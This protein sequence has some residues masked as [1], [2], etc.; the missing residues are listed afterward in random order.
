MTTPDNEIYLQSI[1]ALSSLAQRLADDNASLRDQLSVKAPSAE[2]NIDAF[3]DTPVKGEHNQYVLA[4][5][6]TGQVD[7]LR[8]A[9]H[10]YAPESAGVYSVWELVEVAADRLIELNRKAGTRA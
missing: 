2:V 5:V 10:D 9:L 4:K 1:K 3:K 6:G 7:R 8:A